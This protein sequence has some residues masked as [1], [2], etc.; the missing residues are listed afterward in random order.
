MDDAKR[1]WEIPDGVDVL[2]SDDE[3]LG[4]VVASHQDYVV[5]EK[6][7]FFP[8]DYYVPRSA[9]AAFD[10]GSLRLTVPK[11][12]ALKQ[13]WD[14][15]PEGETWG[16][17]AHGMAATAAA[18]TGIVGTTGFGAIV[19]DGSADVLV[20]ELELP[21][22][23]TLLVPVHAEELEIVKRPL[24]SEL[25]DA[26]QTVADERRRV[27]RRAS[28]G[29]PLAEQT[30]ETLVRTE[31]VET[32]T[33]VRVVEEIEVVKEAVERSETLSATL[34]REVVEV[35]DATT[36][37]VEGLVDGTGQSR[38]IVDRARNAIGGT[39]TGEKKGL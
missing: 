1:Q 10:G 8:T 27:A 5:V 21:V 38:G 34:R 4:R 14:V 30:I 26:E 29:E 31:E 13:G 36:A 37:E 9:F 2:G 11:H 20:G 25:G 24:L 19:D 3:K 39:R 33:P 32:R 22:G 6:G 12:E 18:T 17:G 7:F 28:S 16:G 15:A 35:E 23:E